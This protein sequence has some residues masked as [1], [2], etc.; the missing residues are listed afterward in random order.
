[1]TLVK[2]VRMNSFTISAFST[3]TGDPMQPIVVNHGYSPSATH[4]S[5]SNE[6]IRLISY[7]RVSLYISVMP[8]DMIMPL[9]RLCLIFGK[10]SGQR[11][12]RNTSIS[13]LCSAQSDVWMNAPVKIEK[14]MNYLLLGLR[15][16]LTGKCSCTTYG[17]LVV[18]QQCA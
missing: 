16:R 5:Y 14:N 8:I 11:K 1:M 9:A 3:S 6:S 15:L 10:H 2:C 13:I 7:S 12:I 18:K 4:N 17:W